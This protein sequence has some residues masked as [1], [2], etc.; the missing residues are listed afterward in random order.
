[1]TEMTQKIAESAAFIKDK[2]MIDAE[3]GLVLGSGLGDIVNRIEN[4]IHLPYS[5]IPNFPISTV[6]G[7]ASELVYGTLGGKKVVV[8][9]GRFHFYEGY[10]MEQVIFPIR[11]MRAM[12][13]EN[14]MITNAAGGI[15]WDFKPGDLMLINDQLNFTG[16]NPL[17]GP[18]ED[19]IGPRFVDMSHP[20]DE[21]M[22]SVAKER[23]KA[24]DINL[25]EGVYMG[26]TGPTY[27]TPAEIRMFRTMGADAVG[28]STVSEVIAARHAGMHVLGISCI[29]NLGSGMQK[30]ID[31]SAVVDTV[32]QVKE[33][34][35]DLVEDIISNL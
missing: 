16:T 23:A 27:E 25:H 34:F 4:A 19:E 29:T 24:L 13:I 8:M 15:N 28:M 9:A 17:I 18:N 21:K 26:V 30:D 7:H 32:N 11:V 31:H 3:L 12:G 1:M 35:Q 6:V 2:G 14:L 10:S 33:D 22:M 5:E 20:F